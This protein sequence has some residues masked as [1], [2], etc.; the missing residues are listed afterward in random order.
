[1][2]EMMQA[3]A[4]VVN[5]SLV[6]VLVAYIWKAR[7]QGIDAM[8]QKIDMA[9]TRTEL[10]KVETRL[11]DYARKQDLD[12]VIKTLETL[13]EK[14]ERREERIMTRLDDGNKEFRKIG[15]CI[16]SLD[17]LTDLLKR[18]VNSITGART[19]G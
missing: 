3:V 8:Q 6:I 15:E 18:Q 5:F 7:S 1:M 12:M 9:A 19:C 2:I 16:A 4:P 14:W 17:T 10:D 13:D 11:G